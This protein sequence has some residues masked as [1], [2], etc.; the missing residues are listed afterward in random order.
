MF[1][2]FR[3]YSLL[4]KG[5]V[6]AT[7]EWEEIRARKQR[8]AGE[9]KARVKELLIEALSEAEIYV[10]IQKLEVKE[11]N[12]VL[13]INSG[14]KALIESIYTKL[15]YIVEFMESPK[16]LYDILAGGGTQITLTGDKPNQ[17]A[18]DEINS[19]I[20]RNTQR[21]IPVTMKGLTDLYTKAPY[22]WKDLDVAGCVAELFKAQEIKLQMGHEYLG[23]D[24]KD[25]VKYLTKR[26]Y[27]DRLL[28]KKRIKTP[29][30]LI[31]NARKLAK[32]LFNYTALPGDE[33]GLMN[34]FKELVRDELGEINRLLVYYEKYAYTGRDVLASG[35][36]I[37]S[38]ITKIKDAK[39]FYE[40]LNEYKED[41]LDYGEDVTDVKK[42][43]KNQRGHFD[44]AVEKL[45]IYEKNK[46][47]VLDT[48]TMKVVES[49][50]KIIKS[51]E[52][53]SQIHKLPNLVQEFVERFA[54]LLEIECKP[55]RQVIERD[56]RK[57][58]DELV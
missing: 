15:H 57:V 33:D 51:K 27:T 13:K 29:P 44:S 14:F 9:R 28:V 50:E 41:L 39:E 52:P 37:L 47:Y 21:N 32:E 20:E 3:K 31:Q 42:F 38:G 49:I 22:G 6:S 25:L 35:Q 23:P 11:K 12:P 45:R 40:Q 1:G 19:Y 7:L 16:E 4:Q 46:S 53:Y 54:K 24:D 36:K 55:V 18:L 2:S 34:K 48:E 58:K 8:E 26:D 43:F 10:N 5:G 56:Y 17:L 30:H